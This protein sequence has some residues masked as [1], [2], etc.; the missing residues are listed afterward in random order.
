VG[1]FALQIAKALGGEVTAVCSTA[2]VADAGGLGA[3]HVIDY[4]REDFT[5]GAQRYDLVIDVAGSRPWSRCVRV[6]EPRA[7]LVITTVLGGLLA[8]LALDP[9]SRRPI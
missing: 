2:K 7:T 8:W 3:D 5:E 6:M 1:H 4:T 9:R